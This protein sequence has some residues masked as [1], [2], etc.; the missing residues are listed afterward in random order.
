[1]DAMS[2][3]PAVS[4][5]IAT[6]DRVAPL[7][8]LLRC[9]K[10]Q[11]F[12]DF[13][14]IVVDD[15]SSRET[16]HA[17]DALWAELDARFTLLRQEND[18]TA[19]GPSFTRNKGIRAARAPYVAFCDDDDC[20]TREDHLEFAVA[21]LSTNKADFYFANM[22]TSR[23]GE[24]LG[25]DFYGTI[26][27]ILTQSPIPRTTDL[28]EVAPA[29]R[30]RAMKHIFLHCDSMVVSR[31]LLHKAGLYWEKLFM[32]EDR[33]LALR[34]LDRAQRVLYRDVVAADYD[35]T[36]PTGICKS[37]TED[38]IRQFVILAML[39][40][41]TMMQ[42]TSMKRVARGYRAWMLVELAQSALAEGRSG[43]AREL[44]RQSLLLRPTLAAAKLL[45]GT[46]RAPLARLKGETP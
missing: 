29:E 23:N 30:A 45:V 37:Y 16:L 46:P 13:E 39:H 20:W 8:R 31:A 44:A 18:A 9:V 42:S 26:R 15:A 43:Q 10:Q 2:Q 7:G 35:R 5:V 1:M 32:A 27:S 11:T 40:A 21:A 17:Y 33:D 6:K 19:K 12:S 4:V 3:T 25:P 36:V 34:L 24:I 14:C 41:E 38:E 22:Q 28:F